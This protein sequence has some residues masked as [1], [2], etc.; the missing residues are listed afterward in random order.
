VG[1][2]WQKTERVS[3]EGLLVLAFLEFG[4]AKEH[5]QFRPWSVKLSMKRPPLPLS[6]TRCSLHAA[7]GCIKLKCFFIT[8]SSRPVEPLVLCLME[9]GSATS[10]RL[11]RVASMMGIQH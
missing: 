5:E 1:E 10:C 4:M 7:H 3:G 2:A 6:H 9:A 8:Q 11:Y